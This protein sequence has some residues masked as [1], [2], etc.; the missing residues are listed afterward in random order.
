MPARLFTRPDEPLADGAARA[1]AYAARRLTGEPV[2]RILGRREFWGL[3]F[4]LSPATLVPRPETETVVSAT[5]AWCRRTGRGR[6]P[7]SILDLGTGSGAI[8]VALLSELPAAFGVGADIAPEALVTARRNAVRHG[9]A[10]RAT[11]VAGRWT[12]PLNGRF[13]IVAANPPYIPT[14]DILTLAPEVKAHDPVAA[15]DGGRDGLNACRAIAAGLES[16]LGRRRNGGAGDRQWGSRR[17]FPH[18]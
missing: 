18:F 16:I 8:L 15:L 14:S 17:R 10:G 9:V 1:A 12:A 3:T 5:L 13:D 2:A 11:F 6:E 7:L 4:E